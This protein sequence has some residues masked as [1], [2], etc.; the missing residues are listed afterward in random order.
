[1]ALA[2]A[3]NLRVAYMVR[4]REFCSIDLKAYDQFVACPNVMSHIAT[5]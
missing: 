2:N 1:M 3:N 4:Q 5:F